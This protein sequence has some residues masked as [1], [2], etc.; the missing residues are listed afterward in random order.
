MDFKVL[1]LSGCDLVTIARHFGTSE[2]TV[3][4]WAY[5]LSLPSMITVRRTLSERVLC[6][7]PGMT[8]RMKQA[9]ISGWEARNSGLPASKR[10]PSRRSASAAV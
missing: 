10:S 1:W 2:N 9:A 6:S 5:R 3:K 7:L 8:G 4:Q